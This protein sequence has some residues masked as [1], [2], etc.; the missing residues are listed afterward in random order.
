MYIPVT[1]ESL[2]NKEYL[3]ANSFLISKTML[4]KKLQVDIVKQK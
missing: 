1:A 2:D 4:W 3:H